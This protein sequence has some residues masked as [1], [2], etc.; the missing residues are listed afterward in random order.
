MKA[1]RRRRISIGLKLNIYRIV[2]NK[3]FLLLSA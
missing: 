1:G 3:S 2:L